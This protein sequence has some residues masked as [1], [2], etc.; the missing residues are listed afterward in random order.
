M[1]FDELS[2]YESLCSAFPEIVVSGN[3]G[4]H[5]E[6]EDVIRAHGLSIIIRENFNV[7]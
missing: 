7:G 6:V 5:L 2:Y 4:D 3:L 1:D